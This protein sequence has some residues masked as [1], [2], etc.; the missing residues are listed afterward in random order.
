VT[1]KADVCLIAASNRDLAAA[2]RDGTFRPDLY[3]R[4]RV[5][6][7]AST[8]Y[9]RMKKLGIQRSIAPR[10]AADSRPSD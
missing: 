6:P 1:Y 9:L 7:N 4:L 2:A 8:L 5:F 10:A 3:Y